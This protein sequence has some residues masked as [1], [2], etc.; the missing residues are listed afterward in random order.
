MEKVKLFWT[1]G[2][3]S[4][5][6]LLQLLLEERRVVQTYYIVRAKQSTG[7]EID[8]IN[9]IRRYLHRNY[10]FTRNL[11]EPIKYVNANEI[12]EFPDIRER[13]KELKKDK[14][15]NYQY[16]LLAELCHQLG[17]ED[18]ELGIERPYRLYNPDFFDKECILFK[19]FSYPFKN[20]QLDKKKMENIARQKGWV[21][22]MQL[23]VFC[24]RPKRGRPCGFCGPCTDA[25]EEGLGWRLPLRSRIIAYLQMPFR[26]YWRENYKKHDNSFLKIIPR[27][28]KGRY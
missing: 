15:V 13:Y 5:F 3:D 25:V 6:R 8:A 19:R 21:D 16:V 23:T 20:S 14:K 4:T 26:K 18:V 1:G 11:L 2:W 27:I 24:R 9:K 7:Q 17:I 28:F 12:D 10:H 22:I